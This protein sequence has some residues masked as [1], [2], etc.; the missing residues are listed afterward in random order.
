MNSTTASFETVLPYLMNRAISFRLL[1]NETLV[2]RHFQNTLRGQTLQVSYKAFNIAILRIHYRVKMLRHHDPAYEFGWPAN[3]LASQ[4]V[5]ES[6]AT[7]LLFEDRDSIN[8]VAGHKM[9][10]ARKILFDH[11][12]VM[13]L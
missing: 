1:T 3:N 12:R 6:L 11:L 8:Y 7:M 5:D 2:L 9:Q 10:C 4:L 13:R